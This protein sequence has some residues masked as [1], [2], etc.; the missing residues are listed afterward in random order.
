MPATPFNQRTIDDFNARKGRGVGPW[1]DHLLLMTARGARSGREITTPLVYRRQGD[2]YVVVASKAGAPEN[3]TWYN[4]IRVNPEV[5]VEVAASEGTE[6]FRALAR[7]IPAGPE[8]DRL[9]AHM[10][11]VW[12][13]FRDYAANTSRTIPVVILQRQP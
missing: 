5:E 3:P 7:P 6:R 8:R 9:Y 2:E 1:R 13:S 10:T 12:P 4:N 11:E